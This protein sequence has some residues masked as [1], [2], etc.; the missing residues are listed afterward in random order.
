M[1]PIRYYLSKSGDEPTVRS[2]KVALGA[3]ESDA[4]QDSPTNPHVQPAPMP[5]HSPQRRVMNRLVER[6][7]RLRSHEV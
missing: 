7:N 3:P 1:Q 4:H 2:V 5:D 6:A